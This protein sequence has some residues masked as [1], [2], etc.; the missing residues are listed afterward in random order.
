MTRAVAAAVCCLGL[1][2]TA[3][4]MGAPVYYLGALFVTLLIVYALVSALWALL[5]LRCS[6]QL[7]PGR[8]LRGEAVQLI[9]SLRCLCPLPKGKCIVTYRLPAGVES[10]EMKTGFL[11]AKETR[12]EGISTHVFSGLCGVEKITIGDV[13]GLFRFGRSIRS[14]LPFLS[15]PRPFEIEKPAFFPGEDGARPL[16]RAQEELSSPEDT[17]AYQP[18]DPLKRVHWKLSVQKRELVVRR[19]ETPAPP[20]TLILLDCAAPRGGNTPE[21]TL[22]LRDTLC[23]TAVAAAGLQMADNSPVR[24]PVYGNAATEFSS[25]SAFGIL[26]L[27]EIL[28]MQ[29]FSGAQ[30]FALTL[31]L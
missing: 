26:Q 24:L 10:A 16:N 11:H 7:L 28:A 18:G 15:L 3:F 23:E 29:S 22:C 12:V 5:S 31:R 13:F 14:R 6:H 27:Q 9:V 30:D 8:V 2:I 21:D 25:D 17:R 4:S 19:Y 20:D 1:W